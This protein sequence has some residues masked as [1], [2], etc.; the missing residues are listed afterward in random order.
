MDAPTRRP[1]WRKVAAIALAGVAALI[2]AMLTPPVQ[3]AVV[4]VF[5]G[6]L[7]GLDVEVGHLWAGPWGASVRDLRVTLPGIEVTADTVDVDL[8]FWSSLSGL[9]LDVEDVAAHGVDITV[10]PFA[11]DEEVVEHEAPPPFRGLAPVAR[12]P[13]RLVVRRFA[14]DGRVRLTG[15]TDVDVTGPWTLTAEAIGPG[16]TS[17]GT[18][19]TT[20]DLRSAGEPVLAAVFDGAV[21]LGSEDDG[22]IRSVEAD[23]RTRTTDAADPVGLDTAVTLE[24]D[25]PEERYVVAVDGVGGH[26]LLDLDTRLDPD[27]RTVA[28]T[29]NAQ[30]TPG[31]IA[32]FAAG[33]ALPDLWGRSTGSA[34]VSLGDGRIDVEAVADVE[35][36]DWASVNEGLAEVAN[37][38]FGLDVAGSVEPGRVD[39]RRLRLALT[40]ADGH[41]V[42]RL[43]A[44]HPVTIDL[45]RWSFTPEVWGEPTLRFEADRFPLRW[46]RGFATKVAV[47]Q[48]TLSAALDVI[49]VTRGH[50]QLTARQPIRASGLQFRPAQGAAQAPPV[51]LEIVPRLE[52]ADG[53]LEGEIERLELTAPTGL[54]FGFRG[55][56][57]TS[58]DRWPVIQLDGRVE[59]ALPRLRRAIESLD[60]IRGG[61]QFGFDVERNV[62]T[63]DAADLDVVATTGT[64]MVT[65][66]FENDRPLPLVLPSLQPDWETASP[67]QVRVRFDGLPISWLGP[68]IPEIDLTG[69]S[70]HGE[71]MAITGAGRGVTLE[72]L[73]PFQ[74]RDLRPAYRGRPVAHGATLSVQPSLRLDAAGARVALENIAVRT[75]Q[76]GRIDGSWVLDAPSDGRRRVISNLSLEADFPAVTDRIGRLGALRL[77]QRAEVDLASRRVE[78]TDLRL[79][80]TDKAGTDFLDVVDV[81]PFVVT[82]EP[83]GVWVDSGSSDILLATVTPLEL[84]QVFPEI[85]GL[86]LDGVLPQ[87]QFVGRAEDGRLVLAA[88]DPLVFRDVTV[89]WDE[90][91]LLDR[92]TIG[93]EYEVAYSADGLE[94]RSIDFS[95]LGPRGSPIADASLRAVM[96]LT[97]RSLVESLSFEGTANLEPLARQPIFAGLP[98][99]REGTISWAFDSTF[100]AASS[101]TARLELSGARVDDLGPLPDV[102]AGLDLQAVS[103]Q[104]LAARA[105][106][107]LRSDAGVSDALFEGEVVREND[108]LRFDASLTGDRV[109]VSDVRRFVELLHNRRGD[110]QTAGDTP[111]ATARDRPSRTAVAK[112]RERRDE[113]PFWTDRVAG[114]A[115]LALGR[116]D[117]E[118]FTLAGV[119]GT[120][121]VDPRRIRLDDVAA[122]MLGAALRSEGDLVFDATATDPYEL[123]LTS[124]VTALDIG[125]LF[126]E[127]APE[128]PP[129][130]E[131][132]FEMRMD[133]AGTGRNAI[134]LGAQTLGEIR[135]S[136]RDGI[137]RGLAGRF[138]LARKGAK[139]AGVL[140]FSKELKAIGRMLEQLEEL[141]F[142]TFD[143]V[144]ARPEP[145]RFE[146][147]TLEVVSP[148]A[149]IGGAGGIDVDPATPLPLSP[150]DVR[151]ELA[152]RGD[153]TILFDGMGLLEPEED[154]RGYR[155]LTRPV[156]VSGTVAE[157]D[158]SDFYAMLDDAAENSGGAFGFGLR[159]VNKQ[160]QKGRSASQ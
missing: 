43:T 159:R 2:L 80:L 6:R 9:R 125:R 93:L 122:D 5:A 115:R 121:E 140:L 95:T 132:T 157:P 73:E 153:L 160:L 44:L 69:G 158:T 111:G 103:E 72:S 30:A 83:F 42:V 85:L 3:K 134:D 130:L 17:R 67:Q 20:L 143:L 40:T 128:V 116:I 15:N 47:E 89:R 16:R 141:E 68:Y 32:A 71:L 39:A 131:G 57:A 34:V 86:G 22:S 37:V 13:A 38:T 52:I 129:T 64:S 124:S 105:P 58:R 110:G 135:L 66:R 63:I 137:F 113:V 74:I 35:A 26:R 62:L 81:R 138:G 14:S 126:R 25:E 136:G 148:L 106:F 119:R 23:L 91:T 109:V 19:S 61:A 151:L 60:V 139:V 59:L 108:L 97:D 147:A 112:L 101:V 50:A 98:T 123:E 94:A 156:T 102:E 145:Q 7:D 53:T 31:L 90:A 70:I 10:A 79:G 45:E 24:L 1:R 154:A 77:E 92:V 142:D 84:Q 41:E 146:V 78:I 104:R 48:G 99:A 107:R 55:L 51:D 114:R 65:M 56:A 18:L 28:A 150:L 75:P 46:T 33:R 120:L 4:K 29:W 82:V 133:V 87:G 36:R 96:P 144:L 152:T 76:N 11:A 12:L 155:P 117:L 54:R 21:T 100:G 27:A 118:T 149:H 88:E 49:P 8:A 127:V